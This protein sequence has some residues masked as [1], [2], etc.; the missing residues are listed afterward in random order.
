MTKNVEGSPE[1]GEGGTPLLPCI[2]YIGIATPS[3]IRFMSRFGLS[4]KMGIDFIEH[5]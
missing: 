1:L 2:S 4:L 3:G 5:I